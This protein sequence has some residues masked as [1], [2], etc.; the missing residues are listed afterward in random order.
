ML[1]SSQQH[2]VSYLG[3][4]VSNL[5]YDSMTCFQPPDQV[6][7]FIFF[8]YLIELRWQEAPM[9]TQA[10]CCVLSHPGCQAQGITSQG[11][12]ELWLCR[13][14]LWRKK[15]VDKHNRVCCEKETSLGDGNRLLSHPWEGQK[16]HVTV[17]LGVWSESIIVSCVA[18]M[19]HV[20]SCVPNLL[21][22]L[23]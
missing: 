20:C 23:I 2:T 4:P 11:T 3:N 7:D 14:G 6:G 12:C 8:W 19:C 15:R 16:E 5:Q 21:M 18:S 17:L 13:R 22:V 10:V 1:E 9:T